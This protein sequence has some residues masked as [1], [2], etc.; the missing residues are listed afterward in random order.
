MELK[1]ANIVELLDVLV[2]ED[3]LELVLDYCE[4][5]LKRVCG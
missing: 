1:H 4:T 3:G 5:D 2:T